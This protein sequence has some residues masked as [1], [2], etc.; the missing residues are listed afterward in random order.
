MRGGSLTTGFTGL[1][2]RTSSG[3][4]VSPSPVTAIPKAPVANRAT[5]R[6]GASMRYSNLS[7]AEFKK[8]SDFN[9][10]MQYLGSEMKLAVRFETPET[11]NTKVLYIHPV[12]DRSLNR[13]VYY[14]GSP[15]SSVYISRPL[16]Q[17]FKTVDGLLRALYAE[18]RWSSKF[19]ADSDG[20]PSLISA[21]L[22]HL[23]SGA[24]VSGELGD[25]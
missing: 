18:F 21:F 5:P 17:A 9:P 8:L 1:E 25:N 3:V 14:I 24:K 6:S 7:F 16:S 13:I 20:N 12:K 22:V 4:V 23:S 10:Y 15:G 2:A 19:S 11:G